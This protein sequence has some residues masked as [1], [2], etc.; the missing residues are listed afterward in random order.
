MIVKRLH[1]TQVQAS[2]KQSSTAG[3]LLVSRAALKES[4]GRDSGK[5]R[6]LSEERTAKADTKAVK[7]RHRV[8]RSRVSACKLAEFGELQWPLWIRRVLVRA[9]EGQLKSAGALTIV[10]QPDDLP[11]VCC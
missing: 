11:S 8:T 1:V 9:Q 2:L 4:L 5:L 7:P 10:S 3:D 6:H